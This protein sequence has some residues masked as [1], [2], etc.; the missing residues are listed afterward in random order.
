MTIYDVKTSRALLTK[1]ILSSRQFLGRP[2]HFP[3]IGQHFI[4]SIVLFFT[5]SIRL[6]ASHSSISENIY[7][8]RQNDSAVAVLSDIFVE[9][10]HLE[11]LGLPS[12][13]KD[14]ISTPANVYIHIHNI[15]L[16]CLNVRQ[17]GAYSLFTVHTRDMKW[18]WRDVNLN[19]ILDVAHFYSVACLVRSIYI[20]LNILLYRWKENIDSRSFTFKVVCRICFWL[21]NSSRLDSTWW[22]G[23][24]IALFFR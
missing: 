23:K 12:M 6:Q 19:L 13:K 16:A 17:T 4:L 7:Q 24:D 1:S 3:S 9:H 15:L 8:R 2:K 20:W 14:F 22:S 18:S 11:F 21:E 5:Y 10:I